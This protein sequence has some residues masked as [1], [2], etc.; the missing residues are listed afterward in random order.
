MLY[1]LVRSERVAL[2]FRSRGGRPIVVH[3][4]CVPWQASKCLGAAFPQHV[5]RN[6][7]DQNREDGPKMTRARQAF[8]Y[9]G[10]RQA[11]ENP[12]DDEHSRRLCQTKCTSP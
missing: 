8:R 4:L 11:A 10:P 2:S 1:L 3:W 5:A 6:Q 9:P 12:A 7:E